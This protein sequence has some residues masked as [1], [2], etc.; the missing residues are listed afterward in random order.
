MNQDETI[1]VVVETI[2]GFDYGPISVELVYFT[3]EIMDDQVVRKASELQP[4]QKRNPELSKK[5]SEL[6]ERIQHSMDE[7]TYLQGEMNSQFLSENS[8]VRARFERYRRGLKAKFFRAKPLSTQE[9]FERQLQN[10]SSIS[11]CLDD[12]V[13]HSSSVHDQILKGIHERGPEFEGYKNAQ[14]A[15]KG[16]IEKRATQ[17]HEIYSKMEIAGTPSDQVKYRSQALELISQIEVLEQEYRKSSSS[18]AYLVKESP[19]LT[20]LRQ[21]LRAST[22]YV[23][24]LAHETALL[25]RTMSDCYN[26]YLAMQLNALGSG[27]MSSQ[28]EHLAEFIE[29]MR[30]MLNPN[31]ESLQAEKRIGSDYLPTDLPLIS[32]GNNGYASDLMQRMPQGNYK[33]T[34]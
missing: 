4:A 26:G 23:D 10:I 25:Q 33:E 34:G 17:V 32:M 24:N 13:G 22:N 19:V 31:L 1:D 16:E 12:I 3:G 7:V 8:G 18:V 5:R 6:A 11:E 2:Q 15:I 20:K 14:E 30:D 28:V 29:R 27:A 21:T 9:I